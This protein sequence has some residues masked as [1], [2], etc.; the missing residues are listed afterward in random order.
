MKHAYF[1][2]YVVKGILASLKYYKQSSELLPDLTRTELTG[3]N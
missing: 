3:I 2:N 1:D